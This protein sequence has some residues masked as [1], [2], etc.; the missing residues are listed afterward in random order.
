MAEGE[1][2]VWLYYLDWLRVFAITS[3][4]LFHSDK[5][6]AMEDW[7]VVNLA[8]SLTSTSSSSG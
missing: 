4:F 1:K 7:H 6:F 3:V 5:F 8:R 2:R